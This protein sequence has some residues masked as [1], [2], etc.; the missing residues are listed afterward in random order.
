MTF[1]PRGS[2]SIDL[3]IFGS[4]VTDVNPTNLPP[5]ASPDNSDCFF[6]PGGVFTR[7]AL[8]K[9]LA[10]AIDGDPTILSIKDFNPSSGDVRT[11]FLDSLGSLWSND[12]DVPTTVSETNVTPGVQFKAETA[13]GKQWYA[14]YSILEDL[15]FSENPFVGYDNPLY[16]N[17]KTFQRVTTDAPGAGPA[18]SNLTTFPVNLTARGGSGSLTISGAKS[19]GEQTI[20][21]PSSG[22][23][24]FSEPGYTYQIWTTIAYTATTAVP[25]DWL[26]GTVTVSGLT[27]PSGQNINITGRVLAVSGNT[28]TLS[29]TLY[30]YVSITG[31]SGNAAVGT[32]TILSRQGNIVTA[33]VGTSQPPNMSPGFWVSVLNSN[34]SQINGPNWTITNISRATNGIVTVTISTQLTNL[35]AGAI[36]Y[37]AA[38]DSTDFPAGFQTVY[39]VLS[40]TGGTTIFTYQSLVT[41]AVT[42]V[43]GGSVYQVWSPQSGTNGN[44]A[45]IIATGTDANGFFIEWFQLGPDTSINS[46]GGTPQA[47]VW[48][49]A[50]PGERSAVVIFKSTDG[51]LTAPSVP[52]PVSVLGGGNLIFA[53]NVPLGPSNTAQR[54]IAFTPSAGAN[55]YYITPS[56]VPASG[57]QGPQIA[58][59]TILNDNFTVSAAFDFSDAQL[60]SG[61]QIDIAGNDLFSQ[62]VLGP[63]LGNIEYQGRMGWWGEINDLKN[64]INMGFDGGYDP[65]N[66][67]CEVLA[68][69]GGI[70]WVS[71]S[72]FKSA[73]VGSQIVINGTPV[74]IISVPSP[75]QMFVSGAALPLGPFAFTVIDPFGTPPLGWDLSV[76]DGGGYLVGFPLGPDVPGFSYVI[77][78][79]FDGI[80]QQ[81][82]YQD[83]F[84]G[85]ILQPLTTYFFRLKAAV[86]LGG[87]ATVTANLY[88]PSLGVT[89]AT[90]S[91][92]VTSASLGWVIGT[93]DAAMPATI[94]TDLK[95]QVGC[96]GGATAE[97]M[98]DDMELIDVSDPVLFDQMRLSYFQNP[99]GYDAVS[100][101]LSVDPSE[102]LV[103]AFRQRG[104]LYILGQ[105]SLFQSQNNGTG[106]PNTWDVTQY[107]GVCGCSSPNA[108]DF[109]E[110]FAIWG[111]RYGLREFTGDPTAK[112]I[113]QEF[114]ATWESMNWNAQ[115]SMWV[116][117]DPVNRLLFAGIPVNGAL[118]PNLALQMSYRLS[119]A[120]YNVPDPIHVSQYSGK[121]I[122]TDLGRR[123]SP[124]NRTLNCADMCTRPDGNGSG[125]LVKQICFGGGNG[126]APGSGSGFG[127]F[128]ALDTYNYF[129]I[130]PA[131]GTWNCID[132]DFGAIPM[133][134]T[135][136]FFFN[137]DVEQQPQVTQFRKLFN[138]LAT[139]ALGVGS[140][141]ITPFIDALSNPQ[142]V[143]PMPPLSLT[144]PGFDLEFHPILKG[145]RV[146]FRLEPYIGAPGVGKALALTHFI[147]SGRKDT[148]FPVRGTIFGG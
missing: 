27:D 30:F 39:Q 86:P 119:D 65:P 57:N 62:I 54:V 91:V 136:Y 83:F 70:L 71:G 130:N 55:Y 80:I 13:F 121:M 87:A 28:F 36:V 92:A 113:S 75:T 50:A 96:P 69:Y 94:P 128:Y 123:W 139:H 25:A 41:T 48:A 12:P 89:F 147:V 120:A 107:V 85:P 140:L 26:G 2:F 133:Y 64:L 10:A 38:T 29:I 141:K 102:S 61:T 5:G 32:S 49:Q 34:G 51:A 40:A 17:G 103:G 134:Y 59:G 22:R 72:L 81:A 24:A 52:I 146:A 37:I 43:T 9:Q 46:T 78:Q 20:R 15:D 118:T 115:L 125:A 106:E 98:I 105:E 124:W 111:G 7:P 1:D 76:G 101:V 58:S 60:T 66:G 74:T 99:F 11:M 63:C 100:G 68:G 35:P 104:Y 90:V 18:F 97:V 95:L 88:S 138:F 148:I 127:N 14:F 4:W 3:S 23:G 109:G 126:L 73:W 47:Q 42:S 44:A 33:Y 112:K 21:V 129:P 8:L 145:N 144:D 142:T 84:G 67:E 114:A 122:V 31:Q 19:G 16:F 56:I 79:G 143:L 53:Q 117:N 116:K 93:F 108:V 6:L 131:L 77:P 135:T 110:E 132:D 82:A 137:H 45:E